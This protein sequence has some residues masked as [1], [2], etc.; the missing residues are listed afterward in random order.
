MN[1]DVS[2]VIGSERLTQAASAFLPAQPLE[3]PAILARLAG[4]LY[5]K[6]Y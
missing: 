2:D 6:H 3:A 1:F 4:G 5:D